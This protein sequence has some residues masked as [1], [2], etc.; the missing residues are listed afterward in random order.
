MSALDIADGT[1]E[2]VVSG[3]LIYVCELSSDGHAVEIVYPLYAEY[4]M[5]KKFCP[6][7]TKRF[8]LLNNARAT[9]CVTKFDDAF[10]DLDGST[11]Q[12]IDL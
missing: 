6:I 2:A 5:G 11:A 9:A 8:G 12:M 3:P 10:L 1:I 4:T 7:P